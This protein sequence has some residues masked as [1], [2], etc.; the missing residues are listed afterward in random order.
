VCEAV[1]YPLA[2][3]PVAECAAGLLVA[4]WASFLAQQVCIKIEH[5][6]RR[7]ANRMKFKVSDRLVKARD[8]ASYDIK[9]YV[10]GVDYVPRRAFKGVKLVFRADILD[11]S[12]N[13]S[14][15]PTDMIA[16]N[17]FDPSLV[18]HKQDMEPIIVLKDELK[19]D[20]PSIMTRPAVLDGSVRAARVIKKHQNQRFVE[21][22]TLGRVFVGE[23]GNQ[24][25]VNQIINV[26]NGVLYLAKVATLPSH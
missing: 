3:V 5:F 16:L 14:G 23:K 8:G 6:G 13:H 11:L 22:D 17:V 10:E 24:I 2:G 9:N 4:D 20:E 26:K 25:R 1:A 7:T 15:E 19:Q 18:E 21:T 12:A